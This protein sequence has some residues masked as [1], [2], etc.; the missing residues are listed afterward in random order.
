MSR[1]S[2]LRID[3]DCHFLI[4]FHG[5]HLL[6]SL[7]HNVIHKQRLAELSILKLEMIV[8]KNSHERCVYES[9]G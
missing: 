1:V 2:I 4:S 8:E 5:C 9:V 7:F 3:C 6:N